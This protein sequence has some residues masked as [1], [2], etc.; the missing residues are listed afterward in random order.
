MAF[1]GAIVSNAESCK[2]EEIQSRRHN[3]GHHRK[4]LQLLYLFCFVSLPVFYF[5]LNG[6]RITNSCS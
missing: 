1:S 4:I 2:E 3:E 6:R 5:A